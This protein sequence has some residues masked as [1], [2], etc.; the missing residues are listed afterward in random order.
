M[1]SR[2]WGGQLSIKCIYK[3]RQQAVVR[4]QHVLQI[5]CR[6]GVRKNVVYAV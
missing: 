2:E 4:V 6:M 5:V 3:K 1:E